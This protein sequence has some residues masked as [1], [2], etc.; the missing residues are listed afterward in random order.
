MQGWVYVSEANRW[1]VSAADGSFEI[2]DVPPGE[3]KLTIWHEK[4]GR[5]KATAVVGSDG[6]SKPIEVKMS[7]KKKMERRKKSRP[8]AYRSI[9]WQP[10][11]SAAIPSC[12]PWKCR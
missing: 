7:A 11:T 12:L 4:L 2:K 1:A 9:N 8:A 6:S 5:A 10:N 3:Y